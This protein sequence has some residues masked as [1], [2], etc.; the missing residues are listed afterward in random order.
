ESAL[1]FAGTRPLQRVTRAGDAQLLGS[2]RKPELGYDLVLKLGDPLAF[3]LHDPLAILADD[4]AVM[5]VVRVVWIV[6]L[7][8]L[9]EVHLANQSA[10]GQQWQRTINRGP[11]YGGIPPKGP[12]EQLL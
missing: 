7:V 3:K 9:A 8:V 5:G 12:L 6:E 11:G 10:F 1:V 4:V 2:D